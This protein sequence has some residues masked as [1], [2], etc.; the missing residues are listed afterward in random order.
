MS[1]NT[2]NEFKRHGSSTINGVHVTAGWTE[3]AMA[4]ERYK[5]KIATFS[6]AV[7]STAKGGVTTVNHLIHVFDNCLTGV[8]DIDEFFIM[9]FKDILKD[10]CH[11]IIMR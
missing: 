1:V 9:I 2:V 5:L 7:H 10:V 11:K 6:T 8:S 4:S 3:T